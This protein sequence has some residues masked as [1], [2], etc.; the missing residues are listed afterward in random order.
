MKKIGLVGGISWTSTLEYYRLIN[1]RVN[2]KL[3]G[4]NFAECVIVSLNFDDI[5]K[6]T[7][8]NAYGLLREATQT[9]TQTDVDA[10]ALCANTAHLFADELQ[11]SIG[12]PLIHIG[13]ETAKTV[14]R[15]GLKKIGLL[16]TVHTMQKDFY[17]AKFHALGIEVLVPTRQETKNYIQ[18]TLKEE[19]GRGVLREETKKNY[20]AIMNELVAAGAEGIVLGCTEI[21]LLIKQTDVPVKVFDTTAIH[22]NAIVDFMV[23]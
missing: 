7:W 21:P 8:E 17:K 14:Q 12:V 11:A 16:G 10:I 6:H 5:Q 20:I 2:E 22:V 19:L 18:Q 23:S 9:L 1:E 4:L 3:G 13:E 15:S